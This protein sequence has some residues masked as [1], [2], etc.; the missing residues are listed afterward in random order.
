MNISTD[1]ISVKATTTE[2]L[3]YVGRQEGV[4]ATAV[5]LISRD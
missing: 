5:A 3:G 1:D 2:T 4:N